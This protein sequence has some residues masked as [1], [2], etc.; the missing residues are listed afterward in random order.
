[1]KI[2]ALETDAH[3]LCKNFCGATERIIATVRFHGLRF[4]MTVTKAVFWTI[5]IAIFVTLGIRFDVPA[6][7]AVTVGILAWFILA[8][9]PLLRTFLD[10]KFDML[11]ITT[12]KIVIIDQ[13]SLFQQKIHHLNMENVASIRVETQFANI[14][15]FGR[16]CIELKEGIGEEICL[17][18]IPK[19]SQVASMISDVFVNFEQRRNGQRRAAD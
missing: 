8:F 6:S 19:A 10:W 13:S 17:P 4:A 7:V 12:E 1:M 11:L 14:F 3:K 5:V 15:P 2:F 16:L 9:L 18:Y